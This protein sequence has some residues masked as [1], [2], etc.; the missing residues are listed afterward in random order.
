MHHL[1]RQQKQSY[2]GNNVTMRTEKKISTRIIFEIEE[3][4]E[5]LVSSASSEKFPFTR[6]RTLSIHISSTVTFCLFSVFEVCVG[7]ASEFFFPEDFP[8]FPYLP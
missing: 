7:C 4:K 3:Q 5:V 8:F 2:H 6:V 1:F